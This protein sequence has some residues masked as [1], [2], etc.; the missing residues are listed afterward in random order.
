MSPCVLGVDTM[1]IPYC[2]CQQVRA[3]SP[4][5]SSRD[6]HTEKDS[7]SGCFD[8]SHADSQ[9]S[10]ENGSNSQQVSAGKFSMLYLYTVANFLYM[11]WVLTSLFIGVVK[12]SQGKHHLVHE[13]YC[14]GFDWLTLALQNCGPLTVIASIK[15]SWLS[16]TMRLA[17]QY[18]ALF[19]SSSLMCGSDRINT[20]ETN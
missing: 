9:S 8:L 17:I 3:D 14:K 18:S 12:D 20:F 2:C 19:V 11:Y 7:D 10:S 6:S 15:Y 5:G 13:S 1:S 4:H 16:S